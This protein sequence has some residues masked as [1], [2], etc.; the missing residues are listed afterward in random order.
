[1]ALAQ[2]G[3]VVSQDHR[4]VG[5][6]WGLIAQGIIEQNVARGA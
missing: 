6:L 4:Q 2:L 1:M 5:K 3:A